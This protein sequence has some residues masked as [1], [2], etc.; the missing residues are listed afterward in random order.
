[1]I[2]LPVNIWFWFDWIIKKNY[3]WHFDCQMLWHSGR[4]WS[5]DLFF[6]FRYLRCSRTAWRKLRQAGIN[7]GAC[8]E[9][10]GDS[11]AKDV[12]PRKCSTSNLEEASTLV[13]D[14]WWR[15]VIHSACHWC[16]S[17]IP[18]LSQS[19][20]EQG[21]YFKMLIS[22]LLK[23]KNAK[24]QKVYHVLWKAVG[25]LGFVCTVQFNLS[26]TEYLSLTVSY[27]LVL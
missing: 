25:G 26:R 2:L 3:T 11:S 7:F 17:L 22:R 14:S 18:V 15:T 9:L 6:E 4:K 12:C 16:L 20:L 8:P 13:I 10:C 24:K 5:S 23:I 19:R 27:E 21:K 1:M